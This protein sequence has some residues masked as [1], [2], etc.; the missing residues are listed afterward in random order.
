MSASDQ[1]MKE[2]TGMVGELA[3]HLGESGLIQ[4][5]GHVQE[6]FLARMR[7]VLGR[8]VY[9]EMGSNDPVI[10]AMLYAIE[11]LMRPTTW[12]IEAFSEDAED[13]AN[14][15]F[16]EELFDDMSHSMAGFITDWMAAPQYGYAPFEILWKRR[17]GYSRDPD[18]NSRYSDGKLGIAALEIRHPT[19]LFRWI[20]DEHNR[21]AAMIQ[22]PPPTF[23]EIVLPKEKMLFFATLQRKGNPEGM[24]LLR[25]AFVPWYR[26]KRIEEIES[27]GIERELTGIPVMMTPPEWWLKT[28]NDDDKAMLELA[29]K[30]VKRLRTDEQEGVVLPRIVD[31]EGNQ[32]FSLELMTTGGRRAIDT[33]PPKEYYSRQMAMSILA[34]VILI[35][36]EKVGSH[37]LASSKTNLLAT[38]LGALLDDIE[39]RFNNELIPQAM[40]LNGLDPVRAPKIRHGDIE[41][42]DLGV[43]GE[44]V[45]KLSGAGMQLFPTEDGELERKVLRIAGLPESL[46]DNAPERFREN[47]EARD[48]LER[49]VVEGQTNEGDDE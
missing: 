16:V 32:L 33:G 31:K 15:E 10:G 4:F 11:M 28:A 35:G 25:R 13:Q 8:R 14:S 45:D 49:T 23:R 22:R 6:E 20:F 7:G 3:Q 44:Y 17:N 27:I 42:P 29:K 36:H 2:H 47:A 9:T 24:S 40:V 41:T 21:T 19:S 5:S 37:A 48:D 1:L 30:I 12:T 39:E 18:L 46:A 34:D 43:M 38:G 26:K